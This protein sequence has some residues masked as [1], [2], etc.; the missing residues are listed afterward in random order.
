MQHAHIT[1]MY[2]NA[3]KH[4]RMTTALPVVIVFDVHSAGKHHANTIGR[5]LRCLSNGGFAQH[6]DDSTSAYVANCLAVLY[7][8][9][10]LAVSEAK[11]A[12]IATS[13]RACKDTAIAGVVVPCQPLSHS[14]GCTGNGGAVCSICVTDTLSLCM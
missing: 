8:C 4:E 13:R 12:G 11:S 3:T 7:S 6:K 2:S 14:T 9:C 10:E 5:D 1:H